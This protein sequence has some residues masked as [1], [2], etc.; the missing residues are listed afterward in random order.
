MVKDLA[1]VYG[2]NP[3]PVQ[4][5]YLK[6]RDRI[7]QK[8]REKYKK[9]KDGTSKCN[10]LIKDAIET[11]LIEIENNQS[12][13]DSKLTQIENNQSQIES[14]ISQI[15]SKLTQIQ[16]DIGKLLYLKY[17]NINPKYNY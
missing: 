11:R 1:L 14:K 2:E 15:D 7:N 4:K 16:T 9:L 6:N 3:T 17:N 5:Y 8:Q 13:I 12:E 10:P